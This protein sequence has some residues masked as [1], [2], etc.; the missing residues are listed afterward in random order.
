MPC[1]DG[2][3]L[4]TGFDLPYPVYSFPRGTITELGIPEEEKV[5]PA[6]IHW[7]GRSGMDG[8]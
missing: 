7:H 2:P 5:R 8:R 4:F 6:C 3:G 1:V